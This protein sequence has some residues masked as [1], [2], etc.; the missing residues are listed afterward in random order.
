MAKHISLA[1]SGGGSRAIAFHLGCLRALHQNHLLQD[2]KTISSV[3]GGSVIAAAYFQYAGKFENF[4]IDM[5]EFLKVGLFGPTLKTVFSLTGLQ[6][7]LAECTVLLLFLISVS[8]SCL[9]RL[10]RAGLKMIGFEIWTDTTFTLGLRRLISRTS[11][12]EKTLDRLL[13]QRK[14]L[15]KLPKNGT[16]LIL[17][18]TELTTGSAFR[19]STD[20]SGG[21][22]FGEIVNCNISVAQACH[23]PVAC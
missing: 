11:L 23:L 13:F 18:A 10:L 5:R 6:W 16:K 4:E 20:T 17:N 12:L 8:A 14:T 1:L 3:S 21:W 19:F 9:L 2:I 15:D 7:I 22:R